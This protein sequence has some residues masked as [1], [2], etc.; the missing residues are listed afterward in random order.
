LR[1]NPNGLEF[2]QHSILNSFIKTKTFFV[3]L[4][5]ESFIPIVNNSP[6]SSYGNDDINH[7]FSSP[8][9]ELPRQSTIEDS[10]E[11]ITLNHSQTG[12]NFIDL[13]YLLIKFLFIR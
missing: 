3:Y 5:F 11:R 7:L 4:A 8:I 12:T 9:G 6:G 13:F 10:M 2:K 1:N